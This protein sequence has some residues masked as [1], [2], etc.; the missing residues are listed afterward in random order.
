MTPD[1]PDASSLDPTDWPAFRQLA[2]RMI[3]DVIDGMEAIR[4]RPAWQPVPEVVRQSFEEPLPRTARPLPEVYEQVLQTILPYPR[5]N[6]HPRYWGWV[7][8]SGLPVAML[9]EFLA[10]AMNSS[11][12]AFETAPTMV[13]AQV[14][15]WLKDMLD[16]PADSSAVLTSGCSMS[17]LIA[18]TVARNAKGDDVRRKGVAGSGR[19]TFYGSSETHSSIQK[20]IEILGLGA[21]SFRRVPVDDDRCIRVD[22][23]AEMIAGDRA[24]GL[25]PVCVIGNAGTVL[26]GAVDPLDR[27]A[28]FC[29][30]EDLWF[31]V[32]GAFGA[33]AWI[34]PGLKPL[35]AGLERA[36][37]L[38]FDLHKWMYLPY[39]VACVFVRDDAAHHAAFAMA[40][41]YLSRLPAGPAS[42]PVSFPDRSIEL[43][44]PFRA[45]K[46]WMALQTH[47]L[48]AF[49]AAIARNVAQARRFAAGVARSP[50]L[51]LS[52]TGP[53]N[54][55][56]FRFRPASAA[57][58][59]EQ[60]DDLNRNMLMQLQLSGEAVPSHG[61]VDGRFVLRIAITNHRTTDAD[62][63]LLLNRCGEIGRTLMAGASAGG[64]RR[65]A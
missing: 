36:D 44:R 35:L 38:A 59:P 60:E 27:V 22:V 57:L 7:N 42:Y 21:A 26:T 41:S 20:A 31:H 63:D 39:A 15:R 45:L 11:V 51:E 23:L 58:T 47:G 4:D 18:L 5:G 12:G 48:D 64:D 61:L 1:I 14:L 40:P 54:V 32:D 49:A 55:V 25:K 17:N 2:H 56:C 43:T 3:D 33:L 53:L 6:V 37:S 62:L 16:W 24:A 13:E 8:G 34:V 19:P 30:A 29:A 28:D 10:A 9:A 46:V 65:T 52:A 50:E